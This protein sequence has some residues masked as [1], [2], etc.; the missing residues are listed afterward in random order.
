MDVNSS[1]FCN[2]E[3]NYVPPYDHY[4]RP[5]RVLQYH[6]V[7]MCGGNRGECTV[8]TEGNR[9]QRERDGGREGGREVILY[10]SKKVA[11]IV[12]LRCVVLAFSGYGTKWSVSSFPF[13]ALFRV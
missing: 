4:E 5:Q 9:E 8:N 10:L 1:S 7:G 6:S 12:H 11:R 3:L 13:R 2:Q